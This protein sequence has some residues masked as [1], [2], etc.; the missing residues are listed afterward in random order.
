[1]V[2]VGG[3]RDYTSES[4]TEYYD[5]QNA[6]EMATAILNLVDSEGELQ[7]RRRAARKRAARMRK[8]K[9]EKRNVQ[10]RDRARKAGKRSAASLAEI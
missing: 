10:A 1:M 4:F 2:V 9:K 8:S 6:E 3:V 7:R 5:L